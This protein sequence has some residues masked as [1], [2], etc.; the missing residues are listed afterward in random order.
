MHRVFISD[1]HL[2]SQDERSS[3]LLTLLD[4]LPSGCELY[5]LGD[6]FEAWVGD[7][8]DAPWLAELAQLL[9]ALRQ[10]DIHAFFMHGNRDFLLGEQ[11]AQT[12]GLTIIKA[13]YL[14]EQDTG[15]NWVLCHGDE[16]CNDE[17]E[18]QAVR[19]LSRSD[20]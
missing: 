1:L 15:E 16:L 6:I 17:E 5:L 8:D 19:K 2:D 14:I 3:A 18:Y 11:W 13:P 12:A 20:E 7:D 9:L 10:R 4:E